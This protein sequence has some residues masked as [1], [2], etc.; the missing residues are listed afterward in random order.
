[1]IEEKKGSGMLHLKAGYRG[2]DIKVSLT[3]QEL[4]A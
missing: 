3:N 2:T 4:N 1:M